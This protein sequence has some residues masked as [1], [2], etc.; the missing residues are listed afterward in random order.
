MPIHVL[1]DVTIDRIAAGEVVERPAN[2]IKELVENSIDAGATSVTV[3]IKEGGTEMMR[4][5]D[6]GCGIPSAELKIAFLRHSTSKIKDA[7]DL[8]HIHS[9][10]FRGEALSSISAVS[11]LEMITKTKDS[12]TGTRVYLEGGKELEC[13]EIGAPT[14]TTVI[15]GNLF[16]NTPA[17][18]KFLRTPQTE[19]SY[20][21]DIMERIAL[22]HPDISFQ[23]TSNGKTR[24]HTSGSG[25]LKEVIYRIYGREISN[26]L[27]HLNAKTEGVSLNGFIGK[28]ELVRSARSF[29]NFFVNGRYVKSTEL[30]TA[31]EEGFAGYLMLH[32]F[33]VCF[34]NISVDPEKVDVNV[35]PAK[36]EVRLSERMK[37][38]GFITSSVSACIRGTETLPDKVLQTNEE[39]KE[40][41]NADLTEI[42]S[43]RNPE[44]FEEARKTGDDPYARF[45][46]TSFFSD[47][48]E[49]N[50]NEAD[51]TDS[52]FEDNR[53]PVYRQMRVD[54]DLPLYTSGDLQTVTDSDEDTGNGSSVRILSRTNRPDF[55]LIGIAFDCYMIVRFEDK[56]LLIDQH[57]AHEKVNYERM[58]KRLREGK[59]AS[60]QILPPV[61]ISLS[62]KEESVFNEN[63]DAFLKLGFEVEHFGGSEYAL[64]AVPADLYGHSEKELFLEVLSEL[65]EGTG[66]GGYASIEERIADMA[67]KASVKGGDSLSEAEAEKLIDEMLT[68]ENPYN[69]PHGRPTTIVLTEKDLEKRFKRIVE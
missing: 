52:F 26:A 5:T 68:L 13:E 9:L 50:G 31:V 1:D 25:D 21:C 55:R 44:P 59:V 54:E 12:L 28:P 11:R 64:R 53:K 4:V 35:H 51:R 45:T 42:T 22:S 67:C 56:L 18:L 61:I 27:L 43:G 19:G 69:C 47:D 66:H 48:E 49:E 38:S 33:P 39:K 7:S 2:V 41:R 23:F 30:S 57:A 40:E 14:G 6:N 24:F 8:D 63:A 60:Q 46:S 36:T 62:G 29:E 65:S 37:V 3:E 16:Y 15:A 20:I 17:R 34:L 32:R 10:G 58:I